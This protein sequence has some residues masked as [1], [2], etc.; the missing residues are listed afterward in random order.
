MFEHAQFIKP[1]VVWSENYTGTNYAPMFRK[2]FQV[3]KPGLAKLYVCGLGYA[4]YYINGKLVTEDLFIAPVSDY[5]KT[6]WYNVYDV[7]ELIE[8]G[9]NCMAV[10]CGNGW[11]NEDIP[12]AWE[13][14]KAVWR[15]VPKVILQMDVDEEMILKS[16]NTWKC[17]PES[18]IWYNNLR[19]GEYFDAR[20]YDAD[21]CSIDYDD[22]GWGNAI[23][24]NKPPKGVFW[25]CKCEPIRECEVYTCKEVKQTGD[26]KYVFD[27][28]AEYVRLH[29]SA[30]Y[31]QRRT[32]SHDP[33]Q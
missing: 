17:Q 20:K 13:H 14:N 18:A 6:L 16:D 23:L 32:T 28:G 4:C 1:D 3:K 12:T 2:R 8:I 9:E 26:K 31:R 24:D 33:L 15:D 21:W 22:S 19:D 29:T 10:W 7:S 5:N 25:E 30:C 11:Y 27:M